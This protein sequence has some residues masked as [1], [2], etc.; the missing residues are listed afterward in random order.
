M[1]KLSIASLSA[2]LLL[3]AIPTAA[4]PIVIAPSDVTASSE[5]GLNFTRID[6]Q[7]VDG[8]GLTGG[9]HTSDNPN[10]TMW[11]STGSGNFGG[12]DLDPFVIFDL[13]DFYTVTSFRVWNY[14]ELAGVSTNL[15][16]RGVNQVSVEYG[17]TAALGSTV[18]G[19][20]NFAQA[21]GTDTYT[22]EA[23][24]STGLIADAS[25]ITAFNARYIKFD[26][27]SNYGDGNTFYGLSEVQFSGTLV[28]EP[29]SLALLG[30]GG[31]LIARRRRG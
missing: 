3:S 17:E 10:L 1:I 24:D 26:I 16:N 20:S 31:L 28:P 5:L 21:D 15:T 8:S 7:I 22:G 9:F 27:D 19:I 13:G 12:V 4:A 6:D 18:A 23:F 25:A 14:N 29:S 30:L 2:A 11:L